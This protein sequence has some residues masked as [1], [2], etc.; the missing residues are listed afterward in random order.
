[1]PERS[2]HAIYNK[3]LKCEQSSL[4]WSAFAP[5]QCLNV[6]ASS[7]AREPGEGDS[8]APT[9]DVLGGVGRHFRCLSPVLRPCDTEQ[10]L[11]DLH[12]V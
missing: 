12:G 10:P 4:L 5:L 7:C 6:L 2:S 1:M 9:P 8:V 3:V 11:P